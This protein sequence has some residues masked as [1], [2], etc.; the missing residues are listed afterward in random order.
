MTTAVSRRYNQRE[1]EDD[2]GS[3]VSTMK[4][5][6]VFKSG[7]CKSFQ[8]FSK[9]R[10]VTQSRREYFSSPERFYLLVMSTPRRALSMNF[11]K[12]LTAA[13]VLMMPFSM[14]MIKQ[15]KSHL[16][17]RKL[18]ASTSRQKQKQRE[19]KLSTSGSNL[20]CNYSEINPRIPSAIFHLSL[21]ALAKRRESVLH[22][23]VWKLML[24]LIDL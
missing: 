3:E 8:T 14:M 23:N 22:W 13:Q 2:S 9:T 10:F 17:S 24:K 7:S 21:E 15:L 11:T 12:A 4:G 20:S 18:A 19:G 6:N 16:Q 5:I 1:S